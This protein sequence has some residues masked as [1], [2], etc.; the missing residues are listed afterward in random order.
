MKRLIY[1]LI[2]VPFL[3]FSQT[4][5]KYPSLLWKIS[6]NG[7]KKPSYLYGTMHVSNRVAYYL[8]EQFF[9]ALKSVDVVGLETNPGDWLENMEKTGE[10]E[11]LTQ[12][13]N[14]NYYGGNFYKNTFTVAFPEKRMLQGILSY[15]P[16][17]INGLLYRQNKARENFEESTYIDLFIYQSASKLNKQLISLENF[18]QSEIKARLSA[19]PDEEADENINSRNFYSGAQKI[20]DAY[21]EGN[22]DMLDSLSKLASSK[23]TQRYLID[24]RNVFFV[25]TI[26]SV[27]KTKS[28]FSGV[29]AA[30]LPGDNGVIELLR[31]KGYTVEP[32]FPKVSKKSNNMREELD[33]QVKSVNFEKQIINDTAFSVNLPGKLYPIVNIGNLRYYIHADMINGSFYTIVRL[34]H[35]GPVFNICPDDLMKKVDSL[36]FEN[37]PGKIILKKDIQ[38]NTGIKGIEIVNKT[39]RGD[40]QHYQIYFTDLEMILFKLG[41]KHDYAI[42]NEAKQFFNSIQFVD[43]S[44]KNVNFSPATKGFSVSIANNHSYTKHTGSS[45]IGLVEDL[46]GH[47]KVRKQFFGVQHAVYNDFNY[48]EEDTFELNQLAK[49][50]LSNYNFKEAQNYKAAM[51]QGVPCVRF[52]A[53]NGKGTNLYAKVFIKGVHYYYVYLISESGTSFEHEFFKSFQLMDFAYVNPIKLITDKDF[54]FKAKDEV[55]DNASSRFNESYA[56]AYAAT[57]EK[58]DS[59]KKDYDFRTGNK[60]YYSPSSNEYV[61][62]TY[63]K[64]ND[65]DYRDNK[66]MDE[67]IEK[68]IKSSTSLYL[69][70]KKSSFNEGMYKYSCI[71]KDTA[72][73][74]AIDMR[75]FIKN[76]VMHEITS[77]YDTTIGMQG[78]AR[79]FMD[80]FSPLDS[81]IGK[82]IFENKFSS[83][84]NDLTSTDTL[85]KQRANTSITSV[86]VQKAYAEDFVK[87]ISSDKINKVSEDS[88]AQLFVNGGTLE[89][90]RI[91]EPY[92]K[93]Y[94]QYTD[95]F[96]LQLCLLKGMAYLK[97]QTARNEFYNL[98][99]SEPPLVGADNT[100][101]D[102]FEVL[103]DS[104]ELCKKFFPGMLT[105]T[106]YDEYKDAVYSLMAEMVNK[107]LIPSTVYASQRESI[108]LDANLALKRYTPASS[109]AK[110]SGDEGNF[111]YLEKTAR[112]LA[113]SIKGSL[114]GLSN[115][116]LYKGSGYLKI[117]ESYNRPAL[118][119]YAWIL[120][121]FYKTDEKTRLFFNKLS[122]IKTQTIAMP[123]TIHLLKNNIV[124]NDTLVAHYCRNKYTRAFFYSELEKEKLTDKFDK[125][126]LSQTS[127]IESVLMSHKQLTSFYNYE[128]DKSKK[129]SLD[130]IKEIN[131]SNKYQ[132]GKMYIY[133]NSRSKNEEEQWTAVFVNDSEEPVSSK[134]ELV[135]GNYFIDPAKTEQENINDLLNYFSLSFRKR[136]LVST[137]SYE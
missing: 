31:K 46:F 50:I 101:S 69:S 79:D 64:Y 66:E 41:G 16:D 52:S 116:N 55:T 3:V 119:N 73:V 88:R 92:K 4:P 81:V 136:A 18:A 22:L 63:E 34:K 87:F 131:A 77:A 19:L 29:G 28:L 54:Y 108:L 133:R 25:N 33:L 95:S 129:D 48:L 13:R 112:E 1:L 65:Y 98:L 102:V 57:I 17:I 114:D 85:V 124:W 26:D 5:K 105:L 134:I 137:N 40:V 71:L 9:D 86:G 118:V 91:I 11:E 111:D 2:I 42:G 127:L 121:P 99:M 20:E 76:G 67:K 24:D 37:I 56:K 132:K 122:K 62:I 128:K 80:S 110:T 8:S 43:K 49:S 130:L 53:K 32:I 36:L 27:L 12:M 117:I 96:Y 6:G 68:L 84:L 120:T 83:L 60:F 72:T 30:H 47:S 75:V 45:L 21:R 59:L 103:H 78:W 97:T 58:K 10:L 7:L 126:Y 14:S 115:N 61:N 125:N 44:D 38:S 39:R 23:N 70:N 51:E 90:E 89:S 135:H 107:K 15:D 113:E 100:V 35:L 104:M 123:V 109:K 82:N 74:R 106:K 93:L 94:T